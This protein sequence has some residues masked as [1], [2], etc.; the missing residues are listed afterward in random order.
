MNNVVLEVKNLR[1]KYGDYEAVRG[2]SFEVREGEIV[3]LL[4]PNGAGKTTTINMLLG[5]TKPTVGQIKI[6]G[7]DFEEHREEILEKM[8]FSST[9]AELP[10]RMT[11]WE[12]LY[13]FSL[14]YGVKNPKKR[15]DE[16][17]E[18]LKMRKF[19][20]KKYL[21]LSSGER[22]RVNLC[23]ALINEPKLLLLDEPTASLDPDVSEQIQDFLL[24]IRGRLGMTILYTSHDMDEVTR[25]C[26]RI[27]FL[28]KGKIVASDTPLNLTK[29]IE[30]CYLKLTF[31]GEQEK[32]KKILKEKGLE[33][34]FPRENRV[35][36]KIKEDEL[37]GILINLSDGGIWITE[38]DLKKPDLKD[39]FIRIARDYRRH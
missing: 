18:Q 34:H 7:K 12:N 30:D 14:L 29:M 20:D 22:T 11:V 35:N 33:P 25:M 13:V 16:L 37:P 39:V 38:I 4:G 21:P 8:N 5:V 32:V 23:K 27:V 31:D 26:D 17:L 15:I 3:G 28:Q 9:E 36:L 24:A 1:K 2:I 19:R 10:G 6:F